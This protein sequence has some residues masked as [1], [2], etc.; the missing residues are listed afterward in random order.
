M[1]DFHGD[2]NDSKAFELATEQRDGVQIL[3]AAG[4]LT[5]EAADVVTASIE[6]AT[7]P[8]LIDWNCR[9]QEPGSR[10]PIAAAIHAHR[11]HYPAAF[12]LRSCLGESALL[13]Q[14]ASWQFVLA[15]AECG[16]FPITDLSISTIGSGTANGLPLK[17]KPG[18]I[19]RL[20]E[21][22]DATCTAFDLKEFGLCEDVVGSPGAAITNWT[23]LVPT[24]A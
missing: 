13:A 3:R 2:E 16:L 6:S 10:H 1:T 23:E 7:L 14:S 18:C 17:C 8:L 24:L 12:L 11:L 15:D 5:R 20:G 19:H 9:S 21:F 4:R 22:I